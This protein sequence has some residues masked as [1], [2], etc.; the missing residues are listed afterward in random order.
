MSLSM[1]SLL[2]FEDDVPAAAR[3]ALQA[4]TEAPADR[5]RS[6]LEAAA[7][8]LYREADLDCADARELVGL[9]AASI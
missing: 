4:A 1:L 7:H 2:M 6:L 8:A 5:R 3:A 9:D